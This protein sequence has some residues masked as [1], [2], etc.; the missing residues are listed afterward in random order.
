MKTLTDHLTQYAAYHQDPRNVATHF[1]GI[2]MIVLAVTILLSRPGWMLAGVALTPAIVVAVLSVLFYLRLDVRFGVAMAAQLALSIWASQ[3]FAAQA[4]FVWLGWGLGLFVAGWVIQF[5]GHY[6]EGRNPAFVDDI[7]GLLVGPLFLTAETAFALHL[8][9]EVNAEIQ[10]RL[11]VAQ[12]VATE[13]A[14]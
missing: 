11:G 8:R 9:L 3:W 1:V 6:F 12:R 5:V 4:T 13:A 7:V 10:R 14:T 2:P